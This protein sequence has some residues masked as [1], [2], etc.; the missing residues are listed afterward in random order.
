MVFTNLFLGTRHRYAIILAAFGLFA[1]KE[2]GMFHWSPFGWFF[3]STVG[4][5]GFVVSLAI[6]FLPTITAI[7]RH[8]RNSLAI[9]L[10][11]LFFGMTGIGWI[12][13]LIWSVLK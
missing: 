7:A 13:A 11:N 1:I 2:T 12:V 4:I 5:I 3:G 8:H 6:F 10:V 9:F